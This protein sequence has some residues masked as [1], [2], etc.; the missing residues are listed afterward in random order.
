MGDMQ[1]GNT[2]TAGGLYRGAQRKKRT[3]RA[4]IWRGAP[5]NGRL[6][7]RCRYAMCEATNPPEAARRLRRGGRERS[8]PNDAVQR[9][10]NLIADVETSLR[11]VTSDDAGR[12]IVLMTRHD[13]LN[14]YR[15]SSETRSSRRGES[16]PVRVSRFRAAASPF[17]R[18]NF[19]G[20][21][22]RG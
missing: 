17:N 21:R 11:P 2:L 1:G 20:I 16:F 6:T 22:Q 10:A 7:L 19:C 8:S 14:L 3:N 15:S 12:L 4:G 9:A 13:L 18:D 5:G